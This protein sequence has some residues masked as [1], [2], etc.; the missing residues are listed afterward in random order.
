MPNSFPK[1]S[2]QYILPP[3]GRISSNSPTTG[4]PISSLHYSCGCVEVSHFGYNLY[5]PDDHRG[6]TPFHITGH[7]AVFISEVSV[8]VSS[9][10]LDWVGYITKDVGTCVL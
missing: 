8:Q 3:T 10:S 2:D 5:S 7:V 4:L 6:S 9:I 1:Q